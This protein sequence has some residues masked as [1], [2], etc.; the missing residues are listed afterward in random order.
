MKNMRLLLMFVGLVAFSSSAVGAR[1]PKVHVGIEFALRPGVRVVVRDFFEAGMVCFVGW[2]LV[3][4]AMGYILPKDDARIEKY[5]FAVIA[6]AMRCLWN[7]Q[8][9]RALRNEAAQ[10]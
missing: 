10:Q 2:A 6:V 1:R 7:L 8:R 3:V 9:A 5:T 4:R